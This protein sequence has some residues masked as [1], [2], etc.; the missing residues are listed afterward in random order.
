MAYLLSQVPCGVNYVFHAIGGL[1]FASRQPVEP[2]HHQYVALAELRQH[3]A[4][5]RLVGTTCAARPFDATG[6]AT[7]L[8]F[9]ANAL[10]VR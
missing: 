8:Q 2:R 9:C 10:I 4:Q 6:G 1:I 7:L 3:A 5:L